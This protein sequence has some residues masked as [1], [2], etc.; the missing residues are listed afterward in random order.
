MDEGLAARKK[1][2]AHMK[3]LAL[4]LLLAFTPLYEADAKLVLGGEWTVLRAAT[5]APVELST[6]PANPI[7]HVA[8]TPID[9]VH[10][11]HTIYKARVLP[12]TKWSYVTAYGHTVFAKSTD[13][14]HVQVMAAD[15][16]PIDVTHA[17]C[18]LNLLQTSTDSEAEELEGAILD[19]GNA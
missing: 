6:N 19:A 5:S 4:P 16:D 15:S 9:A 18:V 3:I 10:V 1:A 8:M 14:S 2:N 13:S 12:G 11:S 7:C 17:A